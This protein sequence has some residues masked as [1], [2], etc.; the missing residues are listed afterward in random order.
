[1]GKIFIKELSIENTLSFGPDGNNIPLQPLNVIIGPNG[2][3]K[4]NLIEIISLFQAM[5]T[6]LKQAIRKGG[7]AKDWLWK[8]EFEPIAKIETNLVCDDYI[9]DGKLLRYAMHFTAVNQR[10]EVFDEIIENSE[11]NSGEEIPYFYYKYENNYPVINIK[12]QKRTLQRVTID[13]EQ[14]ILSQR[15]DP[16]QYPELTWLGEQLKKIRIYR[17]WTF[18]R[19]ALLSLPQDIDAPNDYLEPDCRN[20]GLVLNS[21]KKN[22]KVKRQ[23]ISLLG[24]FYEGIEDFDV[25]IE[26]GSVQLFLTEGDL[27]IPATRLSD[28]TLRFLCLLAIL[29]HPTPPPLICIEEPEIG[30][31]TDIIPI[32]ANLLKEASS[33]TQ[34]IVT[35]HS[36]ALVDELTETPETVL[37]CEKQE[38][39]TRL[40]RLK[41]EDLKAWLKKY[42]LGELWRKGEIGGNRW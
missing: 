1:M 34:L 31:H 38:G 18:G 33:R 2:S 40:Q 24:D 22:P 5:P 37:V 3:G 17:E 30:I 15:K 7:G 39:R 20:L 9:R 23:I 19:Q 29:C 4:S 6:D 14:S 26:G 8:G 12:Q 13:P 25:S 21:F 28:G 27:S 41:S 36:E 32:I 35:T 10:F 11:P 42:S 16:D